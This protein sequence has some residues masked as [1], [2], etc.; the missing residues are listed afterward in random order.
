MDFDG[1]HLINAPRALVWQALNDPAVLAGCIPGC[2]KLE[3]T[4][5][6]TY[7]ATV[8]ISIGALKAR[9]SGALTLEDVIEAEA[10]TLRGQGQGGIAGFV[11]GSARVVLADDGEATMLRW[12][13]AGE[14]GGR[15]ASV[16][17]RLVHGFASKTAAAFFQRL[18]DQLGSQPDCA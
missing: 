15:L 13:A 5:P 3:L 1:A 11:S 18:N 17:G 16:G 12:T 2:E 4:G 8:A 14:I 10:Y 7:A 6:S 9:F